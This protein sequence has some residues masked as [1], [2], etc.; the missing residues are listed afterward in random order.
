MDGKYYRR[1]KGCY[2]RRS[3]A[4]HSGFARCKYIWVEGMLRPTQPSSVGLSYRLP[5]V[6][7]LGCQGSPHQRDVPRVPPQRVVPRVPSGHLPKPPQPPRR[8]VHALRLG[9]FPP[10]S[11]FSNSF[12]GSLSHEGEA[13]TET[14]TSKTRGDETPGIIKLH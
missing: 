3:F 2:L 11:P 5:S 8:R 9:V 12:P 7:R 1:T 13:L 14:Q 6:P 4:W 10:F